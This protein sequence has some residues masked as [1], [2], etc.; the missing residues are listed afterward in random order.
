MGQILA[1]WQYP[2]ASGVALDL[3]YWV[4][5]LALHQWI[6]KALKMASKRGAFFVIVNFAIVHNH[7]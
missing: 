3:P 7:T 5:G 4:I 2:V 1:Q 6:A